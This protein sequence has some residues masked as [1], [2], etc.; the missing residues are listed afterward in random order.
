MIT[1]EFHVLHDASC[2]IPSH[3]IHFLQGIIMSGFTFSCSIK[4]NGFYHN[5]ISH[6]MAADEFRSMINVSDLY[7]DN[8][9][10]KK[11]ALKGGAT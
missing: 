3:I 8:S 4:S 5:K 10:Y 6:H 7:L 9:I 2:K 1:I 11:T